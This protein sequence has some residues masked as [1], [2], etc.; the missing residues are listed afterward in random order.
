MGWFGKSEV[1][2][3]YFFSG[4][5]IFKLWGMWL[6]LD[7]SYM[8]SPSETS[9]LISN[10]IRFEVEYIWKMKIFKVIYN[11]KATKY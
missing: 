5:Y 3:H 7:A 8:K 2:S 11:L 6:L 10:N 9:D 1:R 4:R